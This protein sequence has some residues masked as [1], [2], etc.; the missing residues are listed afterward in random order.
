MSSSLRRGDLLPRI[1]TPPPGPR[2][3]ELVARLGRVEAPG[4]S[5]V[6]LPGGALVWSEARG[7]NVVDVDGNRYVDLTAGFGVAAIGHR[8]PR[9]VRAIR[10]QSNRLIHGMGDVAA[11]EARL[12][13]AEHLAPF[14]P[15]DDPRIYPAVSGSDAV[16][17]AL[18]TALLA[19]GRAGI[20]AFDPSY[21]GLTLGSLAVTSRTAFREPFA[22]RLSPHVRRLPWGAD[23]EAVAERCAA[24]PPVGCV[25]LEPIVGR[26]GVLLPPPGWIAE[27]AGIAREAGALL[28]VD[29]IFTGF[30]R[31]GTLF[32]IEAEEVRPDLICLGK[33]LGGGLPI[34]VAA[35]TAEAMSAWP[36]DG[37]PLHTATF[38]GHPL[39]AAAAVETLA[40]FEEE[41]LVSLAA[42]RGEELAA[43]FR[44]WS[45]HWNERLRIRGRGLLW[46][47]ELA[48][49]E[50]ALRVARTARS[51]G[52]LVLRG[53]VDGT[54]L[55]LAP[56]LVITERQLDHSL[57]VLFTA[58]EVVLDDHA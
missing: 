2:S 47:L 4:I 38:L 6:G 52:V 40:I 10:H 50:L 19:T 29:E 31:T 36:A 32:A 24:D 18:K 23:P 11:H 53:G 21:H 22:G 37:E 7:A 39:A 15:I 54:V 8:H 43:R 16:E 41:E 46:G 26:D 3:E 42:D 48:D 30:G 58:L 14:L 34:G 25:L 57:D 49:S 44:A 56:P 9:I 33:A 45:G 5:T 55:Q 35:G 51:R 27:V 12:A 13:L 17:I 1:S 28:I 20:V